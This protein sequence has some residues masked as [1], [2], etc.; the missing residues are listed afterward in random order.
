[1]IAT[2]IEALGYGLFLAAL[3]GPIFVSLVDTSIQ[4][5]KRAGFIL[6][7]GIWISDFIIVALLLLFTD[8]QKLDIPK[9]WAQGMA[10]IAAVI[11]VIIGVTRIVNW[12][13]MQVDD[14]SINPRKRSLVLKGLAVNTINPFTLVFWTTLIA[15]QTLIRQKDE[16]NLLLF[17]G[18]VLLTIV[19]TDT[20]KIYL[21]DGL[22]RLLHS[23]QMQYL[24]LITGAVF[25]ISAAYIIFRFLM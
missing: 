11:F 7:S 15:G 1:M 12:R 2:A 5:G 16:S 24:N 20:L 9:I 17:F 19:G 22:G 25:V 18:V 13:K 14:A 3:V 10:I 23:R 4:Y 8:L 21:A 6:A